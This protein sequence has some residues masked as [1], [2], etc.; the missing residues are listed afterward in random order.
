M[1]LNV[2]E[3]ASKIMANTDLKDEVMA[4]I[5]NRDDDALLEIL[6]RFDIPLDE[7]EIGLLKTALDMWDKK[8]RGED[9]NLDDLKNAAGGLLDLFR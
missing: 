1:S 9:I 4:V 3:I 8:E 5:N 2:T 6:N 7:D